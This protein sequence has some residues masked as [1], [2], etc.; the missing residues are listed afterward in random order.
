MDVA[1]DFQSF[2]AP[3]VGAF[4]AARTWKLGQE[5]G[6][7]TAMDFSHPSDY[8]ESFCLGT[9][10]QLRE[11]VFLRGGFETSRDEGGMSGGFGLHL[12]RRGF[13][14]TVDYAYNDRS[15]PTSTRPTSA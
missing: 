3:T 7:V 2:P 14:V 11:M 6:L 8:K 12:K 1:Q 13:A 9:E 15:R 10:L 4:G 5:V